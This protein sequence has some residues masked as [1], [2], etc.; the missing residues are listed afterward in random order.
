MLLLLHMN[1]QLP[2]HR[3]MNSVS[4]SPICCCVL[5]PIDA[6]SCGVFHFGLENRPYHFQADDS[7]E[8]EE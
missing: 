7:S 5:I 4:L 8:M 6:D 1:W 2:L 3:L